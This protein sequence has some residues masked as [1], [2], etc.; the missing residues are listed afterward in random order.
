MYY[1]VAMEA[2]TKEIFEILAKEFPNPKSELHFES[3]Y[4]LLVAVILSAQC[5]DKRVN[6]VTQKLFAEAPTA[7]AMCDLPTER[8]EQLIYSCGFYKHKTQ[9]LK[10]ASYDIVNRFGGEVPSN[11]EDLRTLAGVG[12]KTANVVYAVGFGGQAIA[13][14]T[15]VFRVSHRLGLADAGTPEQTE[16]QLQ[17]AVD[18]SLWADGHHYLLLHGRYVCKS[19]HPLCG[20]CRLAEYCTYFAKQSAGEAVKK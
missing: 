12:R 5:T 2:R 19:Q 3:P 6:Q 8:L 9:F 17:N 1:T 13:V 14:D 15:H 11:V 18:R 7:Q 4:Q 20:Q 10:Q 16:L